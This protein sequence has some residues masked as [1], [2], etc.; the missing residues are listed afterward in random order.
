MNK[1]VTRIIISALGSI[2][3]ISCQE[4]TL[5]EK[6][7]KLLL[8]IAE[9]YIGYKMDDIAKIESWGDCNRVFITIHQRKED[10]NGFLSFW[11]AVANENIRKRYIAHSYVGANEFISPRDLPT[12]ITRIKG[13][14][15]VMYMNNQE[16]ISQKALPR[17]LTNECINVVKDETSWHILMCK[18]SLEHIVVIDDII[19]PLEC[20]EQ[21]RNFLCNENFEKKTIELRI[22][23]P[24]IDWECLWRPPPFSVE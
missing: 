20:I 12:R 18:K 6:R 17:E 15:V 7:E 21:F 2:V 19:I 3:L 10:F 1:L 16:T 24:I 22:E 8:R 14:Y 9:H 13:R 5:Q 23:K 4:K 11:M